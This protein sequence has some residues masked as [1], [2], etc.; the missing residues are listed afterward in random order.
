MVIFVILLSFIAWYY[1][2]ATRPR[3]RIS[4]DI[5]RRLYRIKS[6]TTIHGKWKEVPKVELSDIAWF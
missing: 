6:A 3:V 5:F 2:W 1:W 4:G